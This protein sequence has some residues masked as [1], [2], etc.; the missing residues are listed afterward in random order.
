MIQFPKELISVRDQIIDHVR[1]NTPAPEA[2]DQFIE[3]IETE[4][5]YDA[6]DETWKDNR[7]ALNLGEF[8]NYNFCDPQL[9]SYEDPSE[10]ITNRMRVTY[11]RKLIAKAFI[12]FDGYECP[13][14]HIVNIENDQHATAVLGWIVAIHGQSGP[15]PKFCGI[16]TNTNTFLQHLR[17]SNYLLIGEEDVLTDE[18][19]LRLWDKS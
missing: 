17:E 11:A 14:V 9:I 12:D 19:I 8:A 18:C 4:Y 15:V 2:L 3:W 10:P 16:F 13:S 7:V 1:A 6:L 5:L